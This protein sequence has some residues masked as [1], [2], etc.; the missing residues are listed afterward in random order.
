MKAI[1][2]FKSLYGWDFISPAITYARL[3]EANPAPRKTRLLDVLYS[4]SSSIANKDKIDERSILRNQST[5]HTFAVEC[6]LHK[7][8]SA[9]LERQ[10]VVYQAFE[11]KT[12]LELAPKVPLGHSRSCR[13]I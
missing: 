5:P 6:G 11:G 2:E 7:H 3:T 10:N 1:A 9:K 13:A 12:L 4:A 8:H